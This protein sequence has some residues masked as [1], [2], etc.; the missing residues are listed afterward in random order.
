MDTMALGKAK[1][2][3]ARR[4][5]SGEAI[6]G[7][8]VL[9]FHAALVLAATG[10]GS[11]GYTFGFAIATA[12]G[13]ALASFPLAGAMLLIAKFAW[14]DGLAFGQA[15]A[16]CFLGASL[17]LFIPFVIDVYESASLLYPL[18]YFVGWCVS[19]TLIPPLVW[20]RARMLDG[21]RIGLRR[22]A[23]AFAFIV[24]LNFLIGFLWAVL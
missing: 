24:P 1:G 16:A 14:K 5:T 15:Y 9:I 18:E 2:A 7:A 8:W 4:A 11:G 20:A 23:I 3:G 22:A 13:A 6:R 19:T 17:G 12:L 21:E 10:P